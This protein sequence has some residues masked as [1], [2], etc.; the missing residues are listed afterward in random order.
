[1]HSESKIPFESRISSEPRVHSEPR[2]PSESWIIPSQGCIPSRGSHLSRGYHP[3]QGCIPKSRVQSEPRIPFEPRIQSKLRIQSEDSF[4]GSLPR[5]PCTTS[6]KY[7][8]KFT[9]CIFVY[10]SL[11]ITLN[12]SRN[13]IFSSF[14]VTKNHQILRRISCIARL[15]HYLF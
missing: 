7:R 15:H 11:P 3:S 12:N 6:S 5:S 2:I 1:M 10:A 9:L 14:C 13:K 4:R 8:D